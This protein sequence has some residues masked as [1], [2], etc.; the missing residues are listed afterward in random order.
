MLTNLGSLP[1]ERIHNMLKMFVVDP[2]T[3]YDK[4]EE[5]LGAFL[6]KLVEQDVLEY[7]NSPFKLKSKWASCSLLAQNHICDQTTCNMQTVRNAWAVNTRQ[8]SG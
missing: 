5:Q 1:L 6:M 8:I 3:K 7:T 2:A 4:S